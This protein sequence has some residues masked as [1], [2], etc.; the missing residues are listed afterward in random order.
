MQH[1]VM[2]GEDEN[3]ITRRKRLLRLAIQALPAAA[4][5]GALALVHWLETAHP[6]L[7]R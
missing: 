3:A 2:T 4:V 5:A 6:L 1:G 7:A